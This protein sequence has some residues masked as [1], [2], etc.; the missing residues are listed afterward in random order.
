MWDDANV[1]Q[2]NFTIR[3][4]TYNVRNLFL[5]GEGEAKPAREVRALVKAIGKIAA[6]ILVLQEVGSLASLEKLNQQLQIP[7]PHIG[8][9]PGNS[10]RGIHLAVFSRVPV[11]LVSHADTPLTTEAGEVLNAYADHVAAEQNLLSS[12]RLQRDVLEIRCSELTLFGVHLKSKGN[13]AWQC[14]SADEIRAVEA[15][16]VAQIVSAAQ[17][18]H[19]AK[20]QVLLG[21][22]N[23]LSSAENLQ[24]INQ[25]GWYDA[26]EEKF[27]RL[28]RNPSTYWPKRRMRLDRILMSPET[29]PKLIDDSAQLFS[30][31][32]FRQASDHLPVSIDL[33]L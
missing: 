1:F 8:C 9:L 22:F 32:L 11:E 14:V 3:I 30:G 7:Y 10:L 2:R 5:C 4:A 27:A 20:S 6:D 31:D 26:H 25:L 23:E 24:P 33:Q 28:G 12:V 15:R 21:D 19:G 13:P 16:A 18:V 29:V 17:A